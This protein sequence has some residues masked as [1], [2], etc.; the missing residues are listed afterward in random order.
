MCVIPT[1]D[2]HND[3]LE[4]SR[5]FRSSLALP[6]IPW[7]LLRTGALIIRAHSSASGARGTSKEAR[8]STKCGYARLCAAMVPRGSTSVGC[9]ALN[10]WRNWKTADCR[11]TRHTNNFR[12]LVQFNRCASRRGDV[13]LCTV[14]G[15]RCRPR[16]RCNPGID[17]PSYHHAAL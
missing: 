8:S 15:E 2:F 4:H 9:N 17:R 3:D 5:L 16:T 12:A 14:G 6:N 11:T 1:K 7:S 13:Q 10:A